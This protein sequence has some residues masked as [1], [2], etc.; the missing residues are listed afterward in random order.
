[1]TQKLAD[2]IA[3]FLGLRKLIVMFCLILIGVIFRLKGLI[4]GNQLVALLQ[5]TTIAFF[6]ANSV[7]RVGDTVKHYVDSKG[8]QVTEQE[9]VVGDSNGN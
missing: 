1:M 5:S 3:I 2:F 9:A 8:Q 7:E 6:A 4:D